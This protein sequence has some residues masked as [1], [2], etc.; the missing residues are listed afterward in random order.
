MKVEHNTPND[1]AAASQES[2]ADARK[3]G[4]K[5]FLAI[6]FCSNARLK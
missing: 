1:M 5:S 2:T 4:L 6:Q 3:D